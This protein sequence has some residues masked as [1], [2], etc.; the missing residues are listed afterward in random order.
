MGSILNVIRYFKRTHLVSVQT[1][2]QIQSLASRNGIGSGIWVNFHLAAIQ[3]NK[4]CL[5]YCVIYMTKWYLLF[6]KTNRTQ[7]INIYTTNGNGSQFHHLHHWIELCGERKRKRITKPFDR[8]QEKC[9]Y[10]WNRQTETE[11][12]HKKNILEIVTTQCQ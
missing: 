2:A 10:L 12:N 1:H 4:L 9:V 7:N 6:R 5:L 8:L 11:N 3:I